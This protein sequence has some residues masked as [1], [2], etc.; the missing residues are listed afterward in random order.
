MNTF[1]IFLVSILSLLTATSS[2]AVTR[3]STAAGGNW[4][5]SST[6]NGG[7]VP[8]SGDDVN[9]NGPVT[10]NANATCKT[11]TINSGASVTFSTGGYKLT[12]TMNS[13]GTLFTNN[14]TFTANDGTVELKSNGSGLTVSGTTVFNNLILDNTQQTTL[15]TA[16]INGTLRLNNASYITTHPTYGASAILEVNGSYSLNGNYYLWPNSN[17][18]TMP[19]SINFVSGTTT[20]DQM[21]CTIKKTFTVSSG[22]TINGTN[23]CFTLASTFVNIIPTGTFNI[24]SIIVASGATWTL[25]A[26]YTINKLK[27]E[28]TGVVN[29]GNYNLAINA[30]TTNGCGING[31]VEVVTGGTFNPGTGTVT[32]TPTNWYNVNGNITFNNLVVNNGGSGTVVIPTANTVTVTGNVTVNS[33]ATVNQ[34]NNINYGSGATVTNNGTTN[35]SNNNFPPTLPTTPPSTTYLTGSV[36][37]TKTGAV[38]IQSPNSVTLSGNLNINAGTSKTLT[39]APAS[40]LIMGN[41]TITADT[42]YV[43]GKLSVS[44]TGG[45]G[46]A[47]LRSSGSPVIVIGSGSTIT[48]NGATAQT[49]TARTDYVHLTLSDAGAKTFAAGSYNVSGDFTVA[50]GAAD[51]TTNNTTFTF[52]GAAQTIKGLPYKDVT[53]SGSGN[54]TLTDS[55]KITGVITLAGSANLLSNGLV[56][57]TSNA[58]GTASIGPITGTATLTG[59]VNYERY[60]PAGRLWRFMGWPIS[61]NTFANSWQNSIYITGSGTGGGSLGTTNSN[62]YDWTATNEG[63]LYYY[64]ETSTASMNA[65]WTM[66]PNTSTAIES[67]RGYRLFVRGDRSQGTVL[68]NGSSYTPLP[69]TLKGTGT[70]NKGDI[71][72]PLTC[73]NGCGT[74]DGWHLIANPYP[75]AINWNNTN[76]KAARASMNATVY[77]YNPTQNRYGSWNP[78][79]GSV[80]GGSANIASGQSFYVKTTGS[81]TLTF[82]E[83]YKVNN[84]TV[85]L[86]G[87]SDALVN[88]LKMQLGDNIKIFDE[89]VVY[90]Y[91]GASNG[92]DTDLD[93][94]KPDVMN[95]SISTYT[96]TDNS[97]LIFNAIPELNNGDADTIMIH[98][99]LASANYTYNITFVGIESFAN[100]STQF[101]LT[102]SYTGSSAVLSTA[103]PVYSFT[104]ILGT[105][106][107]YAS[108]RFKL[109]ITT[110]VGSLPVKLISFTGQKVAK[111]SVLK[112]STAS[113]IDNDRFDIQHS[114]D[115]INYTTIGSVNGS[116]YSVKRIN[117][118]F[119]DETPATGL[120]YYRLKQVDRD[121]AVTLSNVISL[122]FADMPKSAISAT[123]IPAD[124]YI[125]LNLNNMQAVSASIRIVDMV[126]KTM[127]TGTIM[128]DES[129]FTYPIQLDNFKSGVYFMEVSRNDGTIESLKFVKN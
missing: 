90:M 99:P 102:D 86:F 77:V 12:V 95:A 42:V 123:P 61:G 25:N 71:A 19:S 105:T 17:G 50:G 59:T 70:P 104:T 56:T 69:V 67:T 8:A 62:G 121:E 111:T 93:A 110:A 47:F 76:W 41:Y 98:M 118:T 57:L 16:T 38:A 128:A 81:T 7:N 109:I 58:A 112:W 124:D 60:I 24:G 113:E 63:G 30:T 49:I 44:N 26:N 106:A 80:N 20:L 13:W 79:G 75:S 1:R 127:F 116:R 40:E 122:N 43:Y 2:F 115:G 27:I 31:M 73:S 33:G 88:N 21:E 89:T 65:K 11:I 18:S 45:L 55:S 51:I 46:S 108:N 84:A 114:V 3:N 85:G 68:L 66:V 54:K 87:K 48:Y 36:S 10:I 22:A 14:G 94:T 28:N 9:I 32:L 126:G 103:S 39:I 23:S 119:V 35:G 117:Y 129:N 96:S 83:E 72:V 125:T 120:N 74:G 15:G 6:W 82:K 53:F 97:K 100:P 64:N 107:S 78:T 37:G 34:A 29:A 5:S 4:S 92:L 52:N 91:P 101:T